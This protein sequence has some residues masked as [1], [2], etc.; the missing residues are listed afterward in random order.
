MRDA[1][2]PRGD[3]VPGDPGEIVSFV[4]RY[5]EAFGAHLEAGDLILAG[6]YVPQALAI[7]AGEEAIADYGKL[8]R[9]SVRAVSTRGAASPHD[10]PTGTTDSCC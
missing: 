9:V 1:G 6:S 5:L 7:T 3:L 4:A 2:A 10:R 8:G